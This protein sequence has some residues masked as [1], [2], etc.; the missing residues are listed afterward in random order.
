MSRQQQI[1][2]YPELMGAR[3]AMMD[4]TWTWKVLDENGEL[5]C[6]AGK[7]WHDKE[8]ALEHAMRTA[9]ALKDG[10]ILILEDPE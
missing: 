7:N 1:V 8:P 3:E 9:R 6:R 2:I 5:L 10:A 4:G